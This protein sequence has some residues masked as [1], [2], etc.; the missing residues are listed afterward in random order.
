MLFLTG[1]VAYTARKVG[2]KLPPVCQGEHV[3]W[4]AE[5]VARAHLEKDKCLQVSL[6]ATE[7]PKRIVLNETL[8]HVFC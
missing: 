7:N 3:L 4:V 8:R 2:K 6:L 1:T 5:Q